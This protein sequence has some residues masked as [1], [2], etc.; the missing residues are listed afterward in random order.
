MVALAVLLV[1]PVSARPT[2]I[3]VCR[4]DCATAVRRC[5]YPGL[6]RPAQCRRIVLRECRQRG[7]GVCGALFAPT[8]TTLPP[9]IRVVEATLGWDIAL[10]IAVE[11]PYVFLTF[12]FPSRSFLCDGFVHL[13][14]GTHQA[15]LA[16]V[17]P[18]PDEF[19][20]GTPICDYYGGSVV[21]GTTL[22]G[23]PSWLDLNQP[24]IL[25]WDGQDI[26]VP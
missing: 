14:Q 7:V 24:F 3:R 12:T 25:D 15:A 11:P 5:I 9:R 19:L 23:F 8:T 10:R 6:I 4:R 1:S 2:P 26:L 20:S 22:S 13:R 17:Y 16:R 21:V 18:G